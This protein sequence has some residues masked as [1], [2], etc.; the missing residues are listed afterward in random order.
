MSHPHNRTAGQTLE[1]AL[2]Q[3]LAAF[4]D[5][6]RVAL[7][8]SG[9]LDSSVLLHLLHAHVAERGIALHAFH[10]HHGLSANADQW[11]E[12]CRLVCQRL[13]VAFAMRHV[14]IAR[15]G[16]S[17]IEE[18]AREA[19]YAALGALC[20]EHDIGLLVTAHHIDDQAETVLLQL[21]R[22]SGIAGIAGMEA[23][24]RAPVLLGNAALTIA[25]PLLDITRADLESHAREH[26]I[27][28]IED[29]SNR[30]L[31]Y[32]RNALRQAVMPVLE[33]HFPGFA[34]RF[35][36][37]AQH[38]HAAQS[39]LEQ[40]AQQDLEHCLIGDALDLERV[41]TMSDQRAENLFRYWFAVRGL[42]MPST[43]WLSEM[44]YQLAD[45]RPEAQL[46]VTHPDCHVRRHRNRAYIVARENGRVL[47]DPLDFIWNGEA[48]LH[49]PAFRGSLSFE[50][51]AQGIAVD[52]LRGRSCTMHYRQGGERLRLA[53]DRPTRS[54]KQH[55][56]TLDVPAWERETMP[57]VS[58]A[59]K[60]LYAA[61]LGMDCAHFG[62]P[63]EACVALRWRWDCDSV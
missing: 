10:V 38:A 23:S 22:G 40:I 61:G 56:Q 14:D 46:C 59:G 50:P 34:A 54:L 16:G 36:R 30:D 1:E 21:L 31:R 13:N 49:F 51:A 63:G 24:N 6:R 20:A 25:R 58:V 53:A 35:A 39:V 8:F 55:C 57:L 43:A 5:A 4:P 45:A 28:H 60:L 32:A 15:D 3:A 29:E 19:R 33:Q 41:E 27:A 47:S 12:H 2:A 52:W 7:A 42:R 44:R 62:K 18:A 37:T 26:A 17:G 9:G 48:I 11:A